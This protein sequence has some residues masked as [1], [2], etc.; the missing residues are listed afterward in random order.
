MSVAPDINSDAR[1]FI[2]ENAFQTAYWSDVAR[3]AATIQDDA[4]LAYAT[5]K[6]A[7]Y[8]RSFAG[9]AKDLLAANEARVR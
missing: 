9:A 7:A 5:R 4:L 2:A 3:E 8:A 6:A 1:Q